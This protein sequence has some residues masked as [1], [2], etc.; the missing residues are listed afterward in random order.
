MMG[1]DNTIWL[2]GIVTEAAVV[3]LLV[4]RRV[5]RL[6]PLF[7]VYCVWDLLINTAGLSAHLLHSS[8]V[9][10]FYISTYLAETIIDSVLQF[11]VLVELTWSVLRPIRASL[12]RFTPFVIGIAI[13]VVAA[14]VWP[15][16]VIPAVRGVTPVWHVILHLQQTV[17]ILRVLF[18]LLLAG[19]SQFLSIGWQDRELQL[20][21]GLG[22][23]SL[24][25]VAVTMLQSHQTTLDQYVLLNRIAIAGFLCSLLYWVFSFAQKEAERRA[26]TPQMQNMLLAVAGVARADRAALAESILESRGTRKR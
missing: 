16:V 23:Y 18:F 24:V 9:T 2:A 11:G 10:P 22:I 3:G 25:S 26:F 14:V 20:A 8:T 12:P 5:W 17:S 4:Y 21:T 13:L 7:C 19:C 1:L 15:F 6:L